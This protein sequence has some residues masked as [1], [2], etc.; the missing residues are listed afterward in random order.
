MFS[1]VESPTR[2]TH[3]GDQFADRNLGKIRSQAK[4]LQDERTLR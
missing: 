2:V 1:V 3:S 4:A